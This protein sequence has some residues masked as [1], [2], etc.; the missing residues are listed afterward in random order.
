MFAIPAAVYIIIIIE[1]V[2]YQLVLATIDFICQLSEA[3]REIEIP[4]RRL[5]LLPDWNCVQNLL[6]TASYTERKH[7]R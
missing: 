6:A 7:S 5:L 4:L 2:V 3:S 1:K